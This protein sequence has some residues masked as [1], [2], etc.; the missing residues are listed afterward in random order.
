MNKKGQAIDLFMFVILTFIVLII[1]GIFIY[2]GMT[3]KDKMHEALDPLA[4]EE[5][6]Y[7]QMVEESMG[8]V[9]SSYKIL[10]WGSVVIIVGM[11]LGIFIGAWLVQVNPLFFIPW[12]IV[13]FIVFTVSVTM[14]NA[15]EEIIQTPELSS[16]FSGFVGGNFIMSYLP[17][18]VIIIGFVQGI[19]MF[20]SWGK[21][22]NESSYFG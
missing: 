12:I 9:V 19:I 6:N 17:V 8:G 3:A 20:I 22:K 1:C 10:Y 5:S 16:A 18:W 4:T 14:S 2:F 13:V 21:R 15:Y 11:I 7:T